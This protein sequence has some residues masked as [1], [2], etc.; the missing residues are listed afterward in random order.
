MK[1]WK[2]AGFALL[3]TVAGPVWAGLD[4]TLQ[5]KVLPA[6]GLSLVK[7]YITDGESKIFLSIPANWKALGGGAALDFIPDTADSGARLGLY[8]GA[9]PLTID[10]A[11]GQ[12]LLGQVT[13][14][15]P[16]DAKNAKVLGVDIDPLSI[17]GWRTL[18]VTL[19]YEY[20]GVTMRRSVMYLNMLPGRLVQLS[21]VA[22]DTD[23]NKVHKQARQIL[24]SW[25]EPNRDLPPDLQEKYGAGAG[26]G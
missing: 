16:P 7:P 5:H 22:P 20:F 1:T 18:E 14:Q 3:V 11:G 2:L 8:Q 10:A 23:F 12:D 24:T 21:V 15:L 13:S 25:F 17:F 19:S 26:G 4:F 6:D 9:K